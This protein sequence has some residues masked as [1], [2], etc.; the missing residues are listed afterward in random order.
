[1]VGSISMLGAGVASAD[2]ASHYGGGNGADPALCHQEIHQGTVQNGLINIAD[3]GLGLLGNGSAPA[4]ANQQIC[5]NGPVFA[6]NEAESGENDNFLL[7]D[8]L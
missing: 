7:L 2:D 6:E 5:A 4:R 8:V 1:M 3:V